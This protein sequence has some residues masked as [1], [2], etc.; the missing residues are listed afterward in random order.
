MG[1]LMSAVKRAMQ[2][3]GTAQVAREEEKREDVEDAAALA[4][5]PVWLIITV[6]KL[7]SIPSLNS[8][9][10]QTFSCVLLMTG[11]RIQFS[12]SSEHIVLLMCSRIV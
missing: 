7:E 10:Q 1:C 2:T 11:S 12:T 4:T 3:T 9:F 6:A 8:A 5:T